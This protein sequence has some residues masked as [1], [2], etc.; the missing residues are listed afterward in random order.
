[1]LS[2]SRVSV[3]IPTYNSSQWLSQAIESILV[4][5]D[6][7]TEIIIVDDG[8]TDC[9]REIAASYNVVRLLEQSHQGA[10]RARNLGLNNC[11]GEFVKFLDSDDFLEPGILLR[12]V[13]DLSGKDKRL[14]VY[15]DIRRFDDRSGKSRIESVR[16]PSDEDQIYGLLKENIPTSAPLHRRGALLKVGGF[17]ER[18]SRADEYILHLRLTLSGSIFYHLPGVGTHVREHDSPHRISNQPIDE[19]SKANSTLRSEIY[20]KMFRDRFGPEI[21]FQ[22]KRHFISGEF[23]GA[24]ID[25]RRGHLD[26]ARRRISYALRYEP[27]LLDFFIGATNGTSNVVRSQINKRFAALRSG[28]S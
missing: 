8:S 24:L 13:A 3:I 23:E 12:Q 21:P 7:E 14:I 15:S 20:L 10:N 26:S 9:S 22:V 11:T 28:A 2:E 4:Q 16:L 6:C 25:L 27:S 5:G 17:D 19:I 18:T 1:M